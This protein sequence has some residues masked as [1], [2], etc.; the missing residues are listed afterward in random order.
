MA[1]FVDPAS[2]NYR[3]VSTSSLRALPTGMAGAD[4]DTI[5]QAMVRPALKPVTNVRVLP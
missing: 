1:D 2:G 4:Q 3:L 5:E